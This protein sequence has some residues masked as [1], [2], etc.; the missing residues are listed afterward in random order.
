[1]KENASMVST[2]TAGEVMAAM[3]AALAA[4]AKNGQAVEALNADGW[5][6][7]AQYAQHIGRS[8]SHTQRVLRDAVNAR[9]MERQTV[10]L[11]NANAEFGARRAMVYRP[12]KGGE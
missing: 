7:V 3:D 4:K 6:T 1:M 11:T 9:A 10:L 8:L 12:T 2:I 5:V